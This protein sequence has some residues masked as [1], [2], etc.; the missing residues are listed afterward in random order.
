MYAGEVIG[1]Y[2]IIWVGAVFLRYRYTNGHRT[3]RIFIHEWEEWMEITGH[4][5]RRCNVAD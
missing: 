1:E 3:W 4:Y 2:T 5:R